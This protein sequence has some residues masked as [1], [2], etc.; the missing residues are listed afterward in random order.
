MP[1]IR[2]AFSLVGLLLVAAFSG[3]GESPTAAVPP[4]P[5]ITKVV[6]VPFR[7]SAIH[8]RLPS[9]YT[10]DGK[11]ISPPLAW[12]AVPPG[13]EE[14]ALYAVAVTPGTLSVEWAMAGV[15]PSLHHLS[16]GEVPSGAF[17]EEANDGQKRYSIC[18]AKG[19]TKRYEFALYALPNRVRATPEI[20][21]ATL[22]HN[23]TGQI[24]QG[25]SPATGR[26]SATYTRR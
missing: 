9:L 24:P 11:N 17:L 20:S 13:I 26:F 6:A 5:P 21:G 19:Q 7:S 25:R 3:C 10:C 18:P 12:G 23:L 4:L 1:R 15:N 22:L 8:G 2:Y 16:A 14:L